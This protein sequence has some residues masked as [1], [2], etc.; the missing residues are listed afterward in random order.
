M[1][2]D[3]FPIIPR[4][5]IP[6]VVPAGWLRR[7]PP[8][9]RIGTEE[10]DYKLATIIEEQV[11]GAY[12]AQWANRVPPLEDEE[13]LEA[14]WPLVLRGLSAESGVKFTAT[15]DA[16]KELPKRMR[17]GER[18]LDPYQTQDI[19]QL[20]RIERETGTAFML[21]AMGLGKT[22][23]AL[24]LCE[25][26]R[27]LSQ[28][29]HEPTLIV[30]PPD[31]ILDQWLD[32]IKKAI[33]KAKVWDYRRQK[34]D[35]KTPEELKKY[36]YVVASIYTVSREHEA[37]RIWLLDQECRRHGETRRTL[38]LTPKQERLLREKGVE[39]VRRTVAFKP[40][41]PD[42]CLFDVCWGRVVLDEA[43]RLRRNGAM[44]DAICALLTKNTLI[45]TGMPQQNEYL[46]WFPLFN[47]ARLRAFRNNIDGFKALFRNR[48]DNKDWPQLDNDRRLILSSIV[49]GT[50]IRR[51]ASTLFNG[52]AS[53]ESIPSTETEM[54]LAPD[55]GTK[56]GRHLEYGLKKSERG[57]QQ[58]SINTWSKF[59]P[60]IDD[61]G[62][63]RFR[64]NKSWVRSGKG[65]RSKHPFKEVLDSRQA[66]INPLI[67]VDAPEDG[68]RDVFASDTSDC[69]EDEP[70][71]KKKLSQKEKQ[72]RRQNWY[73]WMEKDQKWRSSV[74]E[75]VVEIVKIHL[76][77][78]PRDQKKLE[79]CKTM[80]PGGIIIYSEYIRALDVIEMAI[81]EELGRKCLRRDG[82]VKGKQK[83]K[84]KALED[85]RKQD[86]MNHMILLT[87]SKSGGEGLNLP[88]AATVI[89]ISPSFNPLLDKQAQSRPLRRGQTERVEIYKIM[90]KDSFEQRIDFAQY[91]KL[92]NA[93]G[94]L[95]EEEWQAEMAKSGLS[96]I[97]KESFLQMVS[98]SYTDNNA[99][100]NN[101]PRQKASISRKE[102][103][104]QPRRKTK[105]QSRRES[106]V[107]RMERAAKPTTQTT[108]TTRRMMTTQAQMKTI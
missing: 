95:D 37:A 97:D 76:A 38:P 67:L 15:S 90:M 9:G 18:I 89:Q 1:I 3:L 8:E 2:P 28:E 91:R 106:A 14:I 7:A 13:F 57:Y 79:S 55:D 49:R 103:V 63:K 98:D 102:S 33:P 72:M 40:A 50:S 87:T 73:R 85:F 46:D 52:V 80:G 99:Y 75:K 88:E 16:L 107:L 51:E 105:D 45:L 5:P 10:E 19:S 101:S 71:A 78:K 54:E 66:A 12:G 104:D 61:N 48:K 77:R 84:Q 96:P 11:F 24:A 29:P 26:N 100:T 31:A 20:A 21:H 64:L 74:T 43:H 17:G 83:Q 44:A 27:D 60:Y 58:D 108:Q 23:Q 93:R 56:Y 68:P 36:D 59:E 70:K 92:N 69:D 42:V 32:E 25:H 47:L 30:V 65:S 39:P 62:L 94:I 22:L 41:M 4:A 6:R 82:T 34:E 86:I 35:P 81:K 53:N